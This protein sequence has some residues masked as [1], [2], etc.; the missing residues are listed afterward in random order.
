MKMKQIKD[1]N[2][3]LKYVLIAREFWPKQTGYASHHAEL[4]VC[5]WEDRYLGKP[6]SFFPS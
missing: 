3:L 2:N 1:K 4:F 5:V 6:S